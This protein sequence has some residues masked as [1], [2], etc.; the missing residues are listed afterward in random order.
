MT[1]I[2]SKRFS[3]TLSLTCCCVR[4]CNLSIW[5]DIRELRCS[6]IDG[7]GRHDNTVPMA[8]TSILHH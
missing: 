8:T 5:T 7:T 4:W 2:I 3:P 1:I 6:I